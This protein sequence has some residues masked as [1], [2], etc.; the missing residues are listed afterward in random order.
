MEHR[1]FTVFFYFINA[2]EEISKLIETVCGARLTTTY[3]RVGGVMADLP[4]TF[5]PHLQRV[6]ATLREALAD[7]AGLIGKN[8]IFHDRMRGTGIIGPED[9]IALSFTGPV[10]RSTGVD[11]D[12]RR[13]SPYLIYDRLNFEVPLGEQGDNYDRYLVRMEEIRQSVR[14]IEQ[15]MVQMPE[16]PV[17]IDDARMTLPPKAEVYGTIEGL[18]NHFKI[19]IEGIKPPAGEAYYAVEGANGELGFY[20]VSDGTGYPYR[21]RVRPPCFALM[22]GLS[23]MLRGGMVADIVATFGTIKMIAGENDR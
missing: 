20:V 4:E 2:R 1:A 14:M 16:G 12:V 9:A 3:T 23:K 21:C 6:L 18:M 15:C 22:Q 19:I 17:S 7:G 13:A 8:R 11:F 10:L 5:G